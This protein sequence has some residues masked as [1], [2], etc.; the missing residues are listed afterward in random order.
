MKFI[1]NIGFIFLAVYLILVGIAALIPGI[2]L[3]GLLFG[4]LAIV[5]G[6]FILM[7]K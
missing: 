3:P 1:N 4:I 6:V 7:G 5:A 2:V